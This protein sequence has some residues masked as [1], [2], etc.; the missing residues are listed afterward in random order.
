[1]GVTLLDRDNKICGAEALIRWNKNDTIITPSV[2]IPIAEKSNLISLLCERVLKLASI[3]C[4]KW[5]MAGSNLTIAINL[6]VRQFQSDTIVDTIKRTIH[7]YNI[8]PT[9][10]ELEITES[11]AIH[12]NESVRNILGAISNIGISIA[13]D[14]FGTGYSSLSGLRDLPINIVKIDQ[15]FVRNINIDEESTFMIKAILQLAKGLKLTTIAEGVETEEQLIFLKENGCD[16]AQGYLIGKPMPADE[17]FT[18][19]ISCN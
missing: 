17:F 16:I 3:E 12:D 8:S 7:D 18:K 14:D 9:L 10:L 4:S 13:M 1:M 5:T 15:S 2:F 6:S 19:Y 11:I